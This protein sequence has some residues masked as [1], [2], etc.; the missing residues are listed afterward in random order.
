MV[1]VAGGTYTIGRDGRDSLSLE[2]PAHPVEVK[3]FFIDRTEVTNADYLKFIEATGHPAP[4]NWQDG[5]Y[6]AGDDRLPI[7]EVT[8]QDAASYAEWAGKRL[9]TEAEWEVAA[10]GSDGRIYPWGNR[11]K[12]GIANIGLKPGKIEE[13]GRYPDSASPFGALDMIGNVWEWTA[14]EISRYPGSQAPITTEPGSTY[15]VIRGGAFD[16][17]SKLDASYRGYLDASKP[18]P[19]VGFRC[20]KDAG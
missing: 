5:T 17:D 3:T 7:T 9:P 6:R 15:R 19:K 2:E 10:R 12:L 20:V 16:G 14:D 4:V 18:Y 8:W 13:V 11:W 1:K